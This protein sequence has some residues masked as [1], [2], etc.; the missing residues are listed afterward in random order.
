LSPPPRDLASRVVALLGFLPD[1]PIAIAVSGGGDSMALL[2]MAHAAFGVHITALTVDHRLRAESAAEA[3]QVKRWCRARDIAHVTLKLAEP[4]S[5]SLQA[6]ARAARYAALQG[7]CE[8]RKVRLLF[9]AHT[10]D[11]VAEGFLLRLAR[12]SGLSGLARMAAVR[13]LGPKVQLVRPLLD[14]SHEALCAWLRACGQD[15]I[16]DPSNSDPRFDRVKARQL[17]AAGPLLSGL[18]AARLAETAAR[19]AE[20]EAA[21]DWSARRLFAEMTSMEANCL[22]VRDRQ[23]MAQLPA[24]MQRR[25]ILLAMAAIRGESLPPRQA[26]LERL[27]AR[28]AV[29]DWRGSTLSGCIFRPRAMQLRLTAEKAHLVR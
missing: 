3:L 9:A 14:I 17:L 1:E 23:A 6:A 4:P 21:L 7:W 27:L 12:G 16:E 29:P 22:V 13:P 24:E 8:R 28:L 19:L 5:G 25:L 26:D 18:D 2:L 11:D 10:R 15:W 20:A